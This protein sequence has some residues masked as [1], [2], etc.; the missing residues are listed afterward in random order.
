MTISMDT[1]IQLKPSTVDA[2]IDDDLVLM[3][4]ENGNY[5]NLNPIGASIWKII[6]QPTTIQAICQQLMQTYDIDEASCKKWC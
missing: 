2:E 4:T 6:K 5:Y 3:S 1:S